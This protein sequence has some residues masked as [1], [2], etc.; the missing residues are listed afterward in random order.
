[1]FGVKVHIY[2]KPAPRPRNHPP[3]SHLQLEQEQ[4]PQ[5]ASKV[6]P[7]D[8]VLP[9]EGLLHKAL[10]TKA[11][12]PNR[13]EKVFHRR[14]LPVTDVTPGRRVSRQEVETGELA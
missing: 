4:N 13:P 10:N 14:V 3:L 9:Q 1:M 11:N 7:K 5:L 12:D 8:L 6:R 2:G